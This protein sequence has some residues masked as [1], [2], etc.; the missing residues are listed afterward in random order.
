MKKNKGLKAALKRNKYILFS[1]L[2]PFFL[3]IF[4]FIWADFYPFGN[5]QAAVI[6]LYHQYFPFL[7]ELQHKMQTG[8]SLLY[9]WNGGLG[10]N[11]LS[12]IAYYMASPLYL[13]LL[14]IPQK[15][16]M[17]GMTVL[18]AVKIG[19]AGACMAIYLQGM[20]RRR[21]PALIA[22]SSFYALCAYVMGYYWCLMWLDVVAL[23]PLCMLGLNRLIDGGDFRL[24]TIALAVMTLSNYYIGAI[25]CI[26]I[27]FYY[28]ILF[29]SRD[30]LPDVRGGIRVTVKA[31]LC[32][33][34]GVAMSAV[35]L[36]PV[37]LNLKNTYYMDSSW[38]KESVMYKPIMDVLTNLLPGIAPTVR[39]GLPNIY[40]GLVTVFLV[41]FYFS[42][43]R[44]SLRKRLLNCGMLVFLLLSMNWNQLDFLWHGLHFP[45]QLP[46]RYSFVFSFLMIGMAYESLRYIR[47]LTLHKV[48]VI[49]AALAGYMILAEKLYRDT[50]PSH[51]AYIGLL[52]LAVYG[53]IF[54]LR[55][56]RKVSLRLSGILILV[57]A[58]A[59]MMSGTVTGI[60][61]VTYTDRDQY[62]ANR[63][64]ILTM[65]EEIREKD[66]DFYRMEVLER[67]TL[68]DPM[69]YHYPGLSQF[70][71]T[72]NGKVSFLMDHLGLEAQDVKNRYNYVRSSPLIN[73][74]FNIRYLLGKGGEIT[75]EEDFFAIVGGEGSSVIYKNKYPLSVGFMMDQ[76]VKNWN[77]K[78]ESPFRVQNDLIRT[79]A[80]VSGE[81][82]T[83]IAVP[84]LTGTNVKLTDHRDGNIGCSPDNTAEASDVFMEF[85]APQ[86]GNLYVMVEAD[87]SEW[88][89]AQHQNG[90]TV[91]LQQDCGAAVNIGKYRQGEIAKIQVHYPAGKAQDIR[92]WADTLNRAVWEK[93]YANLADEQLEVTRYGDR[94]IEGSITAR[95]DG[96]LFLSIPEEKGWNVKVD[97]QTVKSEPLADA[98][99]MVPLS[100]GTHQVKLTYLPDGLAAGAAVS[101][102]AVILMAVWC[103]GR[104]KFRKIGKTDVKII[105]K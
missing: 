62:M 24:Y 2:L 6:D 72:V 65:S 52:L 66:R 60:S 13:V 39:E 96:Y 61:T 17:E 100:A 55:S 1:F 22:F 7:S 27:C 102:C 68:N 71:S 95:K 74:M 44:I 88:I 75:G 4:G 69:L 16:L 98:L 97:G 11:F 81:L 82:M 25:M 18:I 5:N 104:K 15:F 29:F 31:I 51:F 35:L 47:E 21:G 23:L 50:L 20:Y 36:L 9:S 56:Q 89:T 63:D 79:A 54:A 80:G 38:P 53:G 73:G 105:Q 85:T 59:E 42:C 10:T 99:L 37:Y 67:M 77:Y 26:F 101:A 91:S 3:M 33:L 14:I 83:P 92:V 40:C 12:M 87:G 41:I 58:A 34:W 46:F 28:P 93:A 8:G 30:R 94:S 90:R 64:D 76:S 45:N 57:I 84:K 43:K 32:S 86:T 70:S 48:G 103:I 19:A 78:Q 49:A